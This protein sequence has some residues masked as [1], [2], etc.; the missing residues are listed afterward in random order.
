MKLQHNFDEVIDRRHTQ[1][2]KWD[3]YGEDVIPM[4]I[5][6][7]D[8]K[9]PE[10][11]V[12]AIQKRAE[13]AVYGYPCI[14]KSYEK[15]VCGWQQRRFHW[16]I[17]AEWVEYTPAVVPAI[18]YAMK[19]FTH[20]GDQVLVQV[21]A[22][23]PFPQVIP[24]N[25]RHLVANPLQEQPDGSWA[26]DWADFEEKAA[27]TRTTMFLLC[28]PH[29]PTGKCFTREELLRMAEICEKHHVFVVSD[30]IH[31]D[32]VYQGNVHI[33]FSSVSDWAANHCVVCVN[34]SK[35]FNIAGFRTGAAIIPN[36]NN[37]DLFY[38]EMANLKAFGRN[39]FG[40]LAVQ[41]AYNE[42]EYYADQLLDYLQA[43][44]QYT[45]TFLESRIPQIKLGPVQA[46]YLLWLDCRALGMDHL[47]LM[48]F[49]LQQAK[50]AM[51]DG[52]T[53]GQGGDGFMRLNI[54]CPRAQLQ[55]A[56]LRMERAVRSLAK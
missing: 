27:D 28:S 49:F 10:P 44:L 21:P 26:V 38:N 34:P 40:M 39:I 50:V 3:T 48:N 51:N 17:E 15:A 31:S 8:F 18:V 14:D 33:P 43:N 37:H 45:H 32:I 12:K 36:R 52:Y 56:L 9:C 24:H 6:D 42:C 46:T 20:P 5:A 53:F 7:T 55:E 25:G 35:T 16:M 19:A 1:C 2:K 54:A 47:S 4:W 30:E 22:Y 13:H 41:T 11:I 29:N 23:H